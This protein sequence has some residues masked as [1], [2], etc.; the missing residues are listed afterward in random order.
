MTTHFG[1]NFPKTLLFIAIFLILAGGLCTYFTARS[2]HVH[3]REGECSNATNTFFN[4]DLSDSNSTAA[5][6][7]PFSIHLERFDIEYHEGTRAPKDYIS[8]ITL[9]DNNIVTP[10]RISMNKIG[11][12]HG[13]RIFQEDY[14]EDLKGSVLLVRYDPWGTTL[15]YIGFALLLLSMVWLLL[16]RDGTF[17]RLLRALSLVGLLQLSLPASAQSDQGSRVS[18]QGS[19]VSDQ[20]SET[21]I[22]NSE[23]RIQNSDSNNF[24]F[25]TFSFQLNQEEAEA[26]GR[27]SIYY[28]GR[29]APFDSYARDYCKAAFPKRSMPDG[30][31]PAQLVTEI[32][33]FPDKWPDQ[34]KPAMKLFPQQN[35]WLAPEDGL[36]EADQGDTLFIAH[37]MDWLK[38]SIM[39]ENHQQNMQIINSIATFQEKR[40]T[41]GSINR[42]KEKIEISYNQARPEKK[43]FLIEI[44]LSLILLIFFITA[45]DSPWVKRCSMAFLL[46]SLVLI[47]AD[48]GL[49]C[50]LSGHNPFSG[51]FDTLMLVSA[52]MLIIGVVVSSKNKFFALPSLIAS[53]FIT[54]AAT[55]MG[56][57]SFSPLMPVLISPWLILHVAIIMS[58]YCFL[59]FTFVLALISIFLMIFQKEKYKKLKIRYLSQ[60][61]CILGVVFL[62]IGIMIGAAWANISWGQYWSWDPKETWA[63]ITLLGYSIA[64]PGVIPATEKHDWLYHLIVIVAFLLLLT[65]YFG[66]NFWMGGMHAY[67]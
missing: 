13:Y 2:V 58:S 4:E 42:Q 36:S 56:G 24:Q 29:I 37:I 30:Y 26:F 12:Y 60:I 28:R 14:D 31:T 5:S 38:Q 39:E 48:I 46:F 11:R 61:F 15:V 45:F 17:R 18:D 22:Q 57:S 51:L 62:A 1:G 20:C 33:L 54:M 32:Y 59:V 44:F 19:E 50:Y 43:I 55:M 8:H 63:L 53:A 7:L 40:C 41:A 34:P 21:E 67:S 6:T 65:T 3:L 16:R 27:L 35:L 47:T 10:I 49:R 66:V 52:G 64:L 25:S 9:I 23:S